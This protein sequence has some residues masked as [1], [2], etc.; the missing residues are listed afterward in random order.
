MIKKR[1]NS[2]SNGALKILIVEDDFYTR[3]LLQR[4]LSPFGE[5]DIAVNGEEALE[6]YRNS[7]DEEFAYD[8][9]CLDIL[10]PV[11]DGQETLKQIREMEEYREIYGADG[12]KIIMVTVLDDNKNILQA[13]RTGCEG[14]IT[15]PI[16]KNKLSA[17]IE[18]LGLLD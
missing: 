9:I 2:V 3:R 4:I 6:A 10:M 12:V 16:D 11:L 15:K 18:E 1:A 14:Y 5:C 13:F 17:K 8:L 7:L